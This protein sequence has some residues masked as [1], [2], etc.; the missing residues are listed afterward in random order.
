MLTLMLPGITTST[1]AR[2]VLVRLV[3]AVA[4]PHPMGSEVVR[5]GVNVGATEMHEDE[6]LED[7]FARA[8]SALDVARSS[9]INRV[10]LMEPDVEPAPGQL[11][12][13]RSR[14]DW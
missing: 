10:H 5:P 6:W 9:G 14:E 7:V 12:Q 8:E 3:Q 2:E 4:S 1:A 11:I 13:F